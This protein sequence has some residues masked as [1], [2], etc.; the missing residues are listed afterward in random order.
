M[1]GYPTELGKH[2]FKPEDLTAA[3]NGLEHLKDTNETHRK[4]GGD[5]LKATTVRNRA[6]DDLM[7]WMGKFK[8]IAKAALRGQPEL[9]RKLKLQLGQAPAAA[10]SKDSTRCP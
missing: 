2:G 4:V 10:L 7:A 8:R 3:L 6:H 5:A 9:G 1:S